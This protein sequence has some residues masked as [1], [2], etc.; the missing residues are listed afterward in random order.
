MSLKNILKKILIVP[1]S[2]YKAYIIKADNNTDKINQLTKWMDLHSI[3][4]GHASAG[5]S[6][7]GFDYQTQTI[8]NFTLTT[9]DL[10]VSIYQPKSRFI[11]TVFEPQSNLV[12]SVTYDITAWNLMYAH[13]L[14]AYATSERV[15]VSK[16]FQTKSAESTSYCR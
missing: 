11:T 5:K 3:K 4:Y 8:G 15:N 7:R 10:V 9:D 13:N 1:T 12:D 14:K 16:A 2:A 6:M